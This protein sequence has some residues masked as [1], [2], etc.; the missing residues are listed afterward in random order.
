MVGG[1]SIYRALNQQPN[2][3]IHLE[4]CRDLRLLHMY[5]IAVTI[6][7]EAGQHIHAYGVLPFIMYV[8]FTYR[9]N[10][11]LAYGRLQVH[12][13]LSHV[14][15]TALRWS[16]LTGCVPNPLKLQDS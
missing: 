4:A 10:N 9:K 15:R 7:R 14:F 13:T 12:I 3:P 2:A 1:F 11:F 16:P 5:S 6:N 8:P